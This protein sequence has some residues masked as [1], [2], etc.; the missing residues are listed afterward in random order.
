MGTVLPASLMAP[1][2]HRFFLRL[3]F[4]TVRFLMLAHASL[5]AHQP[6]WGAQGSRSSPRCH[7]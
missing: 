5:G 4:H 7:L 2:L 1:S 6:F 3:S